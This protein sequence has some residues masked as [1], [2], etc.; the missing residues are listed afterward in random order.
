MT[1]NSKRRSRFKLYSSGLL[2]FQLALTLSSAAPFVHT[3][4]A[5]DDDWVYS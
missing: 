2:I 1:K 4:R 3:V 5:D